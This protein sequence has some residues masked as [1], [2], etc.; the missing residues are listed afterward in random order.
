MRRRSEQ[1]FVQH[2]LPV[3]GEFA[4][5]DDLGFER[6]CASALADYQHIV[7]D[8]AGGNRAPRQH[9]RLESSERLHQTET[10]DLVVS[11]RM[12]RDHR[13]AV[14]RKPDGLRLRDQI[15]DRQN[16]TVFA[17]HHAIAQPLGAEDGC[18]ERVFGN[19]RAHAHH[20]VERR[21]QIEAQ[22]FGCRLQIVRERPVGRLS[23]LI[24]H[25]KFVL[26]HLTPLRGAS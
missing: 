19:L 4:P 3:A 14:G 25:V 17:D 8:C 5:R 12:S 10:G 6:M 7:A 13:A 2:V 11:Q 20:G 9:R 15:A 18:S 16:Q 23:H 24:T 21:C 26:A 1:R 22:F